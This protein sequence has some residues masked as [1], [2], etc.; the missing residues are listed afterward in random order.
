MAGRALPQDTAPRRPKDTQHPVQ[1]K[2]ILAPALALEACRLRTVATQ[3][4]VAVAPR[5]LPATASKRVVSR[6]IPGLMS[7]PLLGSLMTCN[8]SRGCE[9]P[10]INELYVTFVTWVDVSC[11]VLFLLA[12]L[13][14]SGPCCLDSLRII[15]TFNLS[16]S[17][18]SYSVQA[19]FAPRSITHVH[20]SSYFGPSTAFG[21]MYIANKIPKVPVPLIQSVYARALWS[22]AG[23]L[24]LDQFL[25]GVHGQR[26]R[27]LNREAESSCPND[28]REGTESA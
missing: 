9:N 15:T 3:H 8:S 5:L 19:Q 28:L 24:L 25:D 14:G 20:F 7:V 16:C 22:A 1:V 6:S 23:S 10:R 2:A 17:F 11:K 18:P 27:T 4:P 26:F 12:S 21:P 13:P